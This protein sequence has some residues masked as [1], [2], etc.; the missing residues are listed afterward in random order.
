MRARS[1]GQWSAW[2]AFGAGISVSVAANVAHTWYPPAAVLAAW[3]AAHGPAVAWRP[4]LVA[5]IAAAWWPVALLLCIEI[6]TRVQWQPGRRW[7]AARYGGTGVVAVV[8]AVV[9]YRHMAGLLAATGEDG[10][11]AHLG[12]LAVDGL[13]VVA[14]VALLSIATQ[15]RHAAPAGP[16]SGPAARADVGVRPVPQDAPAAP[17]PADS[18]GI[19]PAR[20]A[21]PLPPVPAE[22]AIAAAGPGAG[23]GRGTE[24]RRGSKKQRAAELLATAPPMPEDQLAAWLAGQLQVSTRYGRQL[25]RELAAVNG[26]GPGPHDTDA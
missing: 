19:S 6:V 11:T 20:Q 14:S 2:A 4:G 10:V 22:T 5:Q 24:S 12:P 7:A 16:T 13:M 3:R 23:G 26:S 18:A 15:H 17:T 25:R 1:R 8:A 21:P 9:S